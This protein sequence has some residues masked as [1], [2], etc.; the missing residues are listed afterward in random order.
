MTVRHLSSGPEGDSRFTWTARVLSAGR[1]LATA[2]TRNHCFSVSGR[3]SFKPADPNPSAIEYML[4]ALGADMVD[5]FASA[6]SR[7]G[8]AIHAL[9]VSVQGQVQNPLVL[10]GVIGEEGTA[11]FETIAA[12]LYVAADAEEPALRAVW[13]EMLARAPIVATLQ[14][15][16][17]LT[18]SMQIAE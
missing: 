6:A 9:E 18:L 10:L 7:R 3:A 12:T 2:Y 16:V 14:R 13:D 11:A 5:G 17:S 8:I 4:G 15:A 1:G